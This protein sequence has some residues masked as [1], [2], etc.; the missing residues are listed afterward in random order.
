MRFPSVFNNCKLKFILDPANK[1]SVNGRIPVQRPHHYF[2]KVL[3]VASHVPQQASVT[4]LSD[5]FLSPEQNDKT[6]RNI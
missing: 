4:D 3:L 2:M 1:R 6:P 5:V